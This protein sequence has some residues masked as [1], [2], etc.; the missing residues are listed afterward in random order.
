MS[1]I[2][3]S[4]LLPAGATLFQDPESFLNELSTQESEGIEGGFSG[5]YRSRITGWLARSL[6]HS[7]IK[8]KMIK[9]GGP[10]GISYTAK[11]II[12]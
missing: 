10:I 9:R 11:T 7:K 1:Y 2:T 4:D 6:V 12:R 3:I 8:S 5:Y